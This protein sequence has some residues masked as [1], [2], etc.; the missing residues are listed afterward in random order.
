MD[1][2]GTLR[3]A[4]RLNRIEDKR[5]MASNWVEILA[6]TMLLTG[7]A[8]GSALVTGTARAPIDPK[9]VKIYTTPPNHFEEIAIV[10]ATSGGG[11]TQQGKVDYAAAELKKQAAKLG[12]NG[13]LLTSTSTQSGVI[14]VPAV[15]GGTMAASTEKE[16]LEGRAIYVS[17]E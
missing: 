15:G 8:S 7:C 9:V 10:K 14:G 12:A 6:V 3:T 17:S 2:V 1:V 4:D 13:V 16:V 11:W 5:A